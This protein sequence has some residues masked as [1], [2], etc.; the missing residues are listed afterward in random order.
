MW[1]LTLCCMFLY[2]KNL[3]N[4][5]VEVHTQKQLQ[6]TLR[7]KTIQIARDSNFTSVFITNIARVLDLGDQNLIGSNLKMKMKYMR[8][9]ANESPE[10]KMAFKPMMDAK[11]KELNYWKSLSKNLYKTLL[12]VT[13]L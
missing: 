8:T 9:M 11:K 7:E 6:A 5:T 13:K 3:K 2:F 12:E 1:L 10:V 4:L